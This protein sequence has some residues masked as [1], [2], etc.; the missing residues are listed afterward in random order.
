MIRRHLC[1]PLLYIYTGSPHTTPALRR[2]GIRRYSSMIITIT[3][4]KQQRHDSIPDQSGPLKKK[5]KRFSSRTRLVLLLFALLYPC[6]TVETSYG[7]AWRCQARRHWYE[8]P[9]SNPL[10]FSEPL[11]GACSCACVMLQQPRYWGWF[12]CTVCV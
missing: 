6:C 2:R 3:N 12:Y 7:L 10:V 11:I 4:T 9:S 5:W 8:G 1:I